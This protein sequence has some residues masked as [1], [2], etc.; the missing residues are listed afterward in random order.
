MI[1]L[2]NDEDNDDMVEDKE[3]NVSRTELDSHANMCVVGKCALVLSNTGK[4]A[5]VSPFAPD[6]NAL[7]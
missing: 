4:K 3:E 7:Q 1:A 2:T 5:D 6:C